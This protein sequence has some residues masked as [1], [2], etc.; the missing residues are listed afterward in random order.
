MYKAMKNP[1]TIPIYAA[2]LILKHLGFI[3]LY[4]F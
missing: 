1:I 4:P 3:S 2:L